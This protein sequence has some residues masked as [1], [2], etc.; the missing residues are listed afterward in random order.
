MS[1]ARASLNGS[2]APPGDGTSPVLSALAAVFQHVTVGMALGTPDGRL[3]DAN[4]A[5]AQM[6]GYER[7]ELL[8]RGF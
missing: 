4:P 5:Y 3:I 2:D 8:V 1:K 7:D 6:L